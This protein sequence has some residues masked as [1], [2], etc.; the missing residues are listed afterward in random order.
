MNREVTLLLLA[1]VITSWAKAGLANFWNLWAIDLIVLF[2]LLSCLIKFRS[3]RKLLGLNLIPILCLGLSCTISFLNPSYKTL[4][5]QEWHNLNI[6]AYFSSEPN[7]EKVDMLNKSFQ[8]ILKVQESDP[9]LGL[10]LFLDLKNRY[11][12]RF[13]SKQ[14]ACTQFI[15][16]YE[17]EIG[18]NAIKFIP[19]SPVFSSTTIFSCVHFIFIILFG[20][21]MYFSI[22]TRKEVRI[23]AFVIGVNAGLLALI[24]IIQKLSY[25]PHDNLKEIFG[26]WDTPEPRYFYSSFTYKNHWAC[27]AIISFF[28]SIATLHHR[29]THPRQELIHDKKLFLLIG[30]ILCI[31]ISIPHSGSRSGTMILVL[32]LLFF[33]FKAITNYM[34]TKTKS[35]PVFMLLIIVV[36]SV[37]A[38]SF[39]LNRETSNEMKI[40]TVSQIENMSNNEKP[41]RFLLWQDLLHQIKSNTMWGYGYRS[42]RALNPIYQSS[43]VRNLRS[44]GLR[45]AH[46]KYTPLVGH[47]HSDILEYIS[48][49]G[50]F[51]FLILL[52]YP[53]IAFSKI[54]RNPSTFPKIGLLGCIAY[55]CFSLVDFP[56][57]TP[58]C[59]LLFVTTLALFCKYANLSAS[60]SSSKI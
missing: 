7:F 43:Q 20:I 28:S 35:W 53:L 48:E 12:D 9:D 55:F 46:Q 8:N 24:G 1:M 58:A 11:H 47:G 56:S 4:T 49:F 33:G 5:P 38:F 27:F 16:L 32:G 52:I 13:G 21:V 30:I 14:S 41:L 45:Y 29:I 57:R 26:I 22:R 34:R 25:V 37:F 10:A 42:Y 17:K 6:D 40:N 50:I 39:S 60:P 3:E 31:I 44:I 36:F 51:M 54:L 15:A 18:Q 2:C 23:C 19:S 59:L